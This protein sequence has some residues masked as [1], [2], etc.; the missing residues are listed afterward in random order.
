M[1]AK[2]CHVML[3][4]LFMRAVTMRAARSCGGPCHQ[5][6]SRMRDQPSSPWLR[7]RFCS[8]ASSFR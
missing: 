7:L 4:N 5:S 6:L 3:L 8:H 2:R 1:L